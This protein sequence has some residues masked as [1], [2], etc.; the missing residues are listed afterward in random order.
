VHP[1]HVDSVS[2]MGVVE[3]QREDKKAM[4]DSRRRTRGRKIRTSHPSRPF[5]HNLV[6]P[7]KNTSKIHRRDPTSS[8]SRRRDVSILLFPFILPSI[9]I[10]TT[11]FATITTHPSRPPTANTHP[12]KGQLHRR[13][14]HSIYMYTKSQPTHRQ[15]RRDI[16]I[17]KEVKKEGV[18]KSQR[19]ARRGSRK[20]KVMTMMR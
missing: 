6:H 4:S 13:S 14:F 18:A 2:R 5:T 7:S 12:R 15:I 11:G 17:E 10:S 20:K 3:M 16:E 19:G 1:L 8:R 9:S